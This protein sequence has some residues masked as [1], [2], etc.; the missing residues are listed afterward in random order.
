[1]NT[2]F[3]FKDVGSI[4]KIAT[5][6]IFLALIRCLCEPFRL[7]Y[8]STTPLTFHDV[9]PFSIGALVAALAL[10]AMIIL[11]YFGKYRLIIAIC[12]MTIVILLIVKKIYATP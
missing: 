6:T 8:L 5:L 11:S 4:S 7:Q 9:E 1:M 3:S 12:L 2:K 10:F